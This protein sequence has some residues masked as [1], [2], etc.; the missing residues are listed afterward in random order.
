[1]NGQERKKERERIRRLTKG[2]AGDLSS[3]NFKAATFE[4]RRTNRDRSRHDRER[5]ALER[6]LDAEK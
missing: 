1:M 5:N 2:V 6:E 3:L 4:D